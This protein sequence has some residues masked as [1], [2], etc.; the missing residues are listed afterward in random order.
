MLCEEEEKK[1]VEVIEGNRIVTG[2]QQCLAI[3][4]KP[5]QNKRSTKTL[6]KKAVLGICSYHRQNAAPRESNTISYSFD[7]IPLYITPH[8]SV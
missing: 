7:I 1:E 8:G 3:Y 2:K 5:Q 6:Q 4:S